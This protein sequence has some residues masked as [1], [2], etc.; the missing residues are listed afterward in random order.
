M[1]FIKNAELNKKIVGQEIL[2]LTKLQ[3]AIYY[4]WQYTATYTRRDRRRDNLATT[5]NGT[6][7]I[8]ITTVL[9][10]CAIFTKSGTDSSCVML[11]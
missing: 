1:S 8:E 3:F 9:N 2:T 10:V 11:F 5:G 4:D 7:K 6:L